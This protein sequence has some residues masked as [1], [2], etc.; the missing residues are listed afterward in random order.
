[1]TNTVLFSEESEQAVLSLLLNNPG[2]VNDCANLT[3]NSFSSAPNRT[4]YDA[5]IRL[6]LDGMVPDIS[7]LSEYLKMKGTLDTAGG[8][9]YLERLFEDTYRIENLDSYIKN[10]LDSYRGRSLLSLAK[11]IP[12]MLKEAVDIGALIN[13]IREALGELILAS[14]GERTISLKNAITNQWK[15]IVDR[16]KNSG[17]SGKTTGFPSIDW[18]INGTS[19]GDLVVVAGRPSQGKTAW[20]CNSVL[21]SKIPSLIFSKEMNAS[22]LMDRLISIDSGVDFLNIRQGII[23]D[24]DAKK[25]VESVK[26]LRDSSEIYIDTNYSA[27]LQYTLNTIRQYHYS[28]KIEYVFLDY[29]QLM[30]ERDTNS[31]HEI[32]QIS[33]ALKLLANELGITVF[34]FSQLNRLVEMR[35][36]KRPILSDLRQSGNL[37]EDADVVIFLYRD[38]Y[39]YPET[40]SL[41]VLE[42]IVRKNRN[43][44]IGTVF[45]KFVPETISIVDKN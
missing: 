8:I 43:G 29:V 2:R 28:Q 12:N 40:E 41:G 6:A 18:L 9:E 19:P 11:A 26:R 21:K 4:I 39:Y 35:D 5:I 33:R 37:E 1:M 17:I 45:L 22:V 38:E 15:A 13:Q 16:T 23:S 44:P 31:T 25:L 42:N 30:A 24:T 7:I 34:L 27:D 32:G 3:A 36:D 20:M 14:G 10:V